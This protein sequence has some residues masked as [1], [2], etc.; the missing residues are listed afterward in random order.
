MAD[1]PVDPPARVVI[2]DH[3]FRPAPMT[4]VRHPQLTPGT[5]LW[6]GTCG[7]PQDDH[8]TVPDYRKRRARDIHLR[9]G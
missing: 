1:Y 7:Q 3:V 9:Q 6:L 8:I 5:C 2:E 4:S